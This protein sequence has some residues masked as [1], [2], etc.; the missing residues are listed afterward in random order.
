MSSPAP[1]DF[2]QRDKLSERLTNFLPLSSVTVML[3]AVRSKFNTHCGAAF[4]L[5]RKLKTNI[6][7]GAFFT[8]KLCS[9]VSIE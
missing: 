5:N 8:A 7:F 4:G 9:T 3:K 1:V 2:V 6:S